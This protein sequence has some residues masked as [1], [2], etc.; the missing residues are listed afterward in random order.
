MWDGN[1]I[2][3]LEVTVDRTGSVAGSFSLGNEDESR[4]FQGWLA[5]KIVFADQ[6]LVQFDLVARG[7]CRGHGRWNPGAPAGDFPLA[8]AIRLY[9]GESNASHVLPQGIKGSSAQDYL[10]P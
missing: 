5:G 3:S 4:S 7:E 6:Q 10:D 2:R 8:I 9:D 1:Q